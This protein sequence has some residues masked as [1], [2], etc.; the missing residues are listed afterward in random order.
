MWRMGFNSLP[1]HPQ[2][3][4]LICN[5]DDHSCPPCGDGSGTKKPRPHEAGGKYATGII[6]KT[7]AAGQVY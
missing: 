1:F 4:Y 6:T 5:G 2:D 3:D 7:Y